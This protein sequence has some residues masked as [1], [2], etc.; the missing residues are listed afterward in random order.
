[1]MTIKKK[2]NQT[3]DFSQK[4]KKKKRNILPRSW[5]QIPDNYLQ[6]HR[7]I[8]VG[9]EKPAFLREDPIVS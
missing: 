5:K 9:V 2:K 7:P 3:K 6:E 4:K 8:I 1:M